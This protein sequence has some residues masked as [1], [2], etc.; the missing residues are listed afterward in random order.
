LLAAWVGPELMASPLM[1]SVFYLTV[2]NF[3]G[4][5][6]TLNFIPRLNNMSEKFS[7]NFNPI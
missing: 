3:V 4:A 5:L 7:L 2:A 1:I 6:F